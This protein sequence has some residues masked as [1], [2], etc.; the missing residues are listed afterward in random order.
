[1][2]I[3]FGAQALGEIE[4]KRGLAAFEES[5]HSAEVRNR[6]QKPLQHVTSG[7]A[8][9]PATDSDPS[10]DDGVLA[11]LRISEIGMELPVRYGT[12]EKVLRR[13]PGIVEGTSLP[14]SRGNVAIAAHRDIHFRGLKDLEIGDLINLEMP[15]QTQSYIVTELSVVEPTDVHVLDETGQSVLT[16]LTCYPFYFVGN[17]PQRFVVRAEA[18][19]FIH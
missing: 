6:A 15:D 5:K 14:G 7:T 1:M 12:E 4:R 10:S 19:E 17:A 18:S 8:T 9:A 11:I 16:L 2:L 3:F 13:G